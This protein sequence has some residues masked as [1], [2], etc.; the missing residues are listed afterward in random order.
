M[1]TQTKRELPVLVA[2]DDAD[3]R[4]LFAEAFAE[5][6]LEN[7]V[8]FVENGEELLA[9]LR[10]QREY[11][12]GTAFPTPGLILLDLNMP[13]KSGREALREIRADQALRHLPIVVVSTSRSEDEIRRCYAEGANAFASKPAS[14]A[15]FMRLVRSLGEH[16]LSLVELPNPERAA[17]AE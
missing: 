8:A 2:D 15:G 12:D 11:A 13:R 4:M 10:K 9:Y 14:H 1:N 3:D 6:G 17:A 5:S 7:P 16:W